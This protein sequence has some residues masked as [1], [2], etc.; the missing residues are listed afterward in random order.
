MSN[1]NVRRVKFRDLHP[2]YE[3]ELC[4]QVK[5]V[6]INVPESQSNPL[7]Q[8][9][10]HVG[11]TLEQY[12]DD[13]N[14]ITSE[15]GYGAPERCPLTESQIASIRKGAAVSGLNYGYLV[16]RLSALNFSNKRFIDMLKMAKLEGGFRT[17]NDIE[18]VTIESANGS[19]AYELASLVDKKLGELHEKGFLYG[20]FEKSELPFT[21]YRVSPLFV[22]K[23][24]KHSAG[25]PTVP[26]QWRLII[27]MSHPQGRSINDGRELA[28][29]VRYHTTNVAATRLAMLRRLNPDADIGLSKEDIAAYYHQIPVRPH[30]W[31]QLLIKWRT[32]SD[33]K[34][35]MFR[36]DHQDPPAGSAAIN[37]GK[38]RPEKY[39]VIPV[40]PFGAVFSVC[41]S[42]QLSRAIHFL[43]LHDRSPTLPWIP[44]SMRRACCYCDDFFLQTV[45]KYAEAAKTRLRK[46]LKC[47]G[48]PVSDDPSKQAEAIIRAV[49]EY[50]GVEFNS[51][52]MTRRMSDARMGKMINLLEQSTN[53]NYMHIRK[54]QSVVGILNFAAQCVRAGRVFMRRL[55][56]A[57]RYH[58]NKKWVK[59]DYAVRADINWWIL[60]STKWNGASLIPG[61]P[62]NP[63][64]KLW[65][66]SDSNL[67][68]FCMV[69][70]HK[71][72]MAF[73]HYDPIIVKAIDDD[74]LSISSLEI[75]CQIAVLLMWPQSLSPDSMYVYLFGDNESSVNSINSRRADNAAFQTAL[76]EL[77]S[78][79]V[80]TSLI[81]ISIHVISKKNVLADAPTRAHKEGWSRFNSYLTD[82][83]IP[84]PKQISLPQV[85]T[86]FWHKCARNQRA[87][88]RRLES[89]D[90]SAAS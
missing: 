90:A 15:S 76:R 83:S 37:M 24:N 23:R 50:L 54:F 40:C 41:I 73:G 88:R 86:K 34:N 25:D 29:D 46:I 58:K 57:M 35:L 75:M 68:H 43:N 12:F 74:T 20:P 21:H 42:H 1:S 10:P 13:A 28:V 32:C 77:W 60:I 4:A 18:P 84:F 70:L 30:D 59:L 82:H 45:W 64:T 27:H 87:H 78:F 38:D 72:E 66:S 44:H 80:S 3:R 8:L 47:A 62:P 7:S 36:D 9:T 5:D 39:F 79:E 48:V 69:N 61:R 51:K 56:N 22:I 63:P 33:G 81:V 11:E 53:I 65:L 89:R 31:W 17:D 85:V 71:G 16:D 6:G 49:C 19:S 14:Y 67:T 2:E 55:W 26:K 52:L